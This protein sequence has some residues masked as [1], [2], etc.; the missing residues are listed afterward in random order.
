MHTKNLITLSAASIGCLV[1]SACGGGSLGQVGAD[2]SGTETEASGDGSGEVITTSWG[3]SDTDWYLYGVESM[4]VIEDASGLSVTVQESAGSEENAIRMDAESVDFGMMDVSGAEAALGEHELTTLYPLSIVLW[5]L[6]VGADTGVTGPS[7]L[8]GL[9]WNA[10]PI[11]GG[12]TQTTMD[13]LAVLDVEPDYYE[14][15]LGD[16]V[17]AYTGRQI[18]GFSY[19]GAGVQATGAILE[20]SSSRTIDLISFTDDEM[21]SIVEAEPTLVP[22]TI[23]G[24][25]YQ[26]VPED[27]NTF[28]YWGVVVGAGPQVSDDLAYE[29]T[30]TFWDNIAEVQE[31]LPQTE[32]LTPQVAVDELL[33]PLHPGAARYYAEVGVDVPE[34]MIG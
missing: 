31:R 23:P 10:G 11:G 27:V 21:A 32:G 4:A 19:R 7:G 29:V 18:Q 34:E 20:A 15:G 17:S 33:L 1:L 30:K 13:A 24:G 16:A 28:G 2:D 9:S 25:T 22:V 3:P 26:D 6:V 8:D 5:Q 12:S 14:A